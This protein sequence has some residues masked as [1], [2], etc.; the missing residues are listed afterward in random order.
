MPNSREER[1]PRRFEIKAGPRGRLPL[2]IML[3]SPPGTGKTQTAIELATGMARVLGKRVVVGDTEYPRSRFFLGADAGG[4]DFDP[5]PI[6]PPYEPL[7]AQDFLE[8]FR[9]THVSVF[10]SLSDLHEGQGGVIDMVTR[11]VDDRG[12]KYAQQAWCKVKTQHVQ[13]LRNYLQTYTGDCVFTVRAKPE[14]TLKKSGR[15]KWETICGYEYLYISTLNIVMLT[16]GV[17]MLDADRVAS[18]M[19]VKVPGCLRPILEARSTLDARAGEELARW[20]LGVETQTPA[21]VGFTERR[22]ADERK[23]LLG[24]IGQVFADRGMAD[25]AE[26][27]AKELQRAFG[28]DRQGVARLDNEALAAGLEKLRNPPAETV[29]PAVS[30]DDIAGFLAGLSEIDRDGY[31]KAETITSDWDSL[32]QDHQRALVRSGLRA[33]RERLGIDAIREQ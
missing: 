29:E 11:M 26:H 33:A 6:N 17:P 19:M 9:D 27:K 15:T 25:D 7:V 32:L 3:I 24:Q 28:T 10:D 4:Y 13:K 2:K 20:A 5:V 21:S 31:Q 12:E 8:A 16:P 22:Y 1:Q 30:D 23:A 18:E 14:F